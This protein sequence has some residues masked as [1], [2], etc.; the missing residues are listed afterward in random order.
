MMERIFETDK[1]F[2]VKLCED[3]IERIKEEMKENDIEIKENDI[4]ISNAINIGWAY[5]FVAA[6]NV[7]GAISNDDMKRL[8]AIIDDIKF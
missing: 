5:G 6:M 8:N 4:E 3:N 7:T 2:G 1:G